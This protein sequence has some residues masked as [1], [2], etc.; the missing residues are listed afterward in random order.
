MHAVSTQLV[1]AKVVNLVAH[2]VSNL[3]SLVAQQV[4]KSA[5]NAGDPGSIP[6]WEGPQEKETAT[7]SRWLILE[8]SEHIC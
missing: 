7:H 8:C 4:K 3:P 2:L 6:G 1:L 5:C